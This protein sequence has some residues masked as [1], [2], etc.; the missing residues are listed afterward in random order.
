MQTQVPEHGVAV[1][2]IRKYKIL[3][4]AVAVLVPLQFIFNLFSTTF[5][6]DSMY[7][8]DRWS[9]SYSPPPPTESGIEWD[10]SL[11][12]PWMNGWRRGTG[13]GFRYALAF[14][15]DRFVLIPF[16]AFLFG[17]HVRIFL[18]L[19]DLVTKY[20]GLQYWTTVI[21]FLPLFLTL[22][23]ICCLRPQII[24]MI[25]A[26]TSLGCIQGPDLLKH[27]EPSADGVAAYGPSFSAVMGLYSLLVVI[28][29]EDTIIESGRTNGLGFQ[30]AI[31]EQYH[32]VDYRMFIIT[33][34]TAW[35]DI[36]C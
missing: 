35:I 3:S 15:F 6:N 36:L 27:I 11:I 30:L 29:A 7:L 14:I 34:I 13:N 2:G 33:P 32:P 16:G 19:Q 9:F 23:C 25:R 4:Y 8:F 12:S 10:D 31:N 20:T 26:V 1:M 17:V 22:E 21:I 18:A 24:T 28:N 5:D